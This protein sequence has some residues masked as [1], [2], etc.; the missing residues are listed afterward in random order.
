MIT[1]LLSELRPHARGEGE[2]SAYLGFPRHKPRW[3]VP[4]QGSQR[5]AHALLISRPGLRG[6]LLRWA[7]ARGVLPARK[8]AIPPSA[9]TAIRS[10]LFDT[11][12]EDEL[13]LAFYLGTPGAYRKVT[14]Q[15]CSRTGDVLAYAKLA[16]PGLAAESLLSEAA[17]LR[18][19]AAAVELQGRIPRVLWSGELRG[20][21]ALI[22]SPGHGRPDAGRL[23]LPHLDFLR[24]LHRVSARRTCF[25]ESAMFRSMRLSAEK[26]SRAGSPGAAVYDRALEHLDRTFDGAVVSVSLAHRDFA[27]WNMHSRGDGSSCSTG[28]APSSRRCRSS[29]RSTSMRSRRRSP[30]AATSPTCATL[31][32]EL[33]SACAACAEHP[34]SVY[35]AYLLSTAL[36][37]RMARLARP[38]VGGARVLEW[39]DRQ[40][41]RSLRR[42]HAVA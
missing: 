20:V 8:V 36:D 23:R 13:A 34:R 39:Y 40:I 7:A 3:L 26:T 31:V 33:G 9:V 17:A 22:T 14:V 2:G 41:E 4:V 25:H 28:S 30:G 6:D 16:E 42:Q 32:M 5:F 38:D 29:A 11:L 18:T 1:D 10:M 37:Y 35:L 15:A 19:L 27:P 12:G 21:Q 24:T